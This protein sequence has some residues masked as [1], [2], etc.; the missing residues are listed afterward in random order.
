MLVTK[1]LAVQLLGTTDYKERTYWTED[2]KVGKW[3]VKWNKWNDILSKEKVPISMS[4]SMTLK[5]W[6]GVIQDK[7]KWRQSTDSI[8]TPIGIS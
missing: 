8:R 1:C 2:R 7:W 6:L 5:S 3:T 4:H